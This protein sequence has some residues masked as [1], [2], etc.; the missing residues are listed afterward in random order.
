MKQI[1]PYLNFDGNTREA[2]EFYKQCLG[3]DLRMMPFSDMP[4]EVP[5][6]AKDRL[7]H[8]RLSK[9]GQVLVMGSD[10]M[11]GMPFQQGNNFWVSVDCE[12]VN[13]VETL[14]AAF[15]E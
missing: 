13:E 1:L 9:D 8:A 14:C 15:G 4:G 11:P 3:G 12:S 7:M 2:M 10:T 5:P 6:G